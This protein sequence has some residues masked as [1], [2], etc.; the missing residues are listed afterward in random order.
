MALL[1]QTVVNLS[2]GQLKVLLALK[3]LITT[4][5]RGMYINERPAPRNEARINRERFVRFI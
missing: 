5:M 4:T 3:E 1:H 2:G